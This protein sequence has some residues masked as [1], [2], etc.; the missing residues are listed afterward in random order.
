MD[1]DAN[2]TG[3]EVAST[4]SIIVPRGVE[5]WGGYTDDYKSPDKNGFYTKEGTTYTDN[6]DVM[7]RP[8]ASS[9]F[10]SLV[11]QA[12]FSGELAEAFPRPFC[13]T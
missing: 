9:T 4:Y 2:A 8:A 10:C 3:E 13:V 11:A 7:K 5:L 6:R 1:A 12:A